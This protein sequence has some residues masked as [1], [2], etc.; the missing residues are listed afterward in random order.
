[1]SVLLKRV[2]PAIFSWLI[3]LNVLFTIPYPESIT[4]AKPVEL[5]LFFFTF[6]FAASFLLNVFLK[7]IF[8]SLSIA[9][10]IITFLLLKA[11]D[12]LNFVTGIIDITVMFL[13]V[14]YF[15]KMSNKNSLNIKHGIPKIKLPNKKNESKLN[16][17]RRR[18][19]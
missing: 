18:R 12:S 16:S 2:L 8:I 11:L 7:N 14:S 17:S 19:R 3:F 1:M 9:F 6:Y 5:T 15:K 10:G 13:L 4:Q